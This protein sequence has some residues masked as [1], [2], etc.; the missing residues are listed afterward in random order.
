MSPECIVV[1]SHLRFDGVWQRPQ[2]I[3]T[4]L[5]SHVPVLFVE[6][7]FAA[8]EDRDDLR[9]EGGVTVL[10]PRRRDPGAAAADERTCA[11]VRAWV[12]QRAAC[13][14]LYTPMMLALA[15]ALP[16]EPIVY[17]CM[18]EL[19]AFDF[20]PPELR[21]RERDLLARASAIFCGGRSLFD[22]RRHLG[23]RV[24]LEPSGVEYDHF[25]SARTRAPH[26]L[27]AHL[28]HPIVGYVGVIDERIDFVILGALA[29]REASVVLV[30]PIVKIDPAIL[31][32]RTNVHFTGQVDY[33]DLPAYLAGFDVALMPFARNAATANISP[34]KTPEYLAAGVPV[35]STPIADVVAA[36]GGVVTIANADFVDATFAAARSSPERIA[37]GA[38]RARE[39]GWDAIVDRMWARL[40]AE[41]SH[42]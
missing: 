6:E 42:A 28:P 26:D 40:E 38:A 22:A 33:R 18:D 39:A 2:Q 8:A 15:D 36:Y 11:T 34:T 12:A 30:G 4:R 7:P 31:P 37:R 10:R 35:V 9:T 21:A 32:Q 14:W 16:G 24:H 23:E 17:D 19:A 13:V 20:A 29:A 25:A 27:L 41:A 3:V 5:A 1:G